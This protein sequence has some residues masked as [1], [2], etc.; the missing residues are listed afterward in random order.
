MGYIP[1]IVTLLLCLSVIATDFRIVCTVMLRARRDG[2]RTLMLLAVF[3]QFATMITFIV[4]QTGW[5][6][7]SHD[8]LVGTSA[9]LGWLAYDYLNKLF[10]LTAAVALLQWLNYGRIGRGNNND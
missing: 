9:Q 8:E 3:F 6:L 5:V 7:Q 4:V 1:H 2:M 10:H